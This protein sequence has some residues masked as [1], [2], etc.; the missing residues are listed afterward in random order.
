M[1]MRKHRVEQIAGGG[2]QGRRPSPIQPQLSMPAHA[3]RRN[4]RRRVRC[5]TC[6]RSVIAVVLLLPGLLL[7]T[8]FLLDLLFRTLVLL[9]LHRLLLRALPH[10]G[11]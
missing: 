11:A 9:L 1:E 4:Y 3:S 10:A 5:E 8:L 6:L 2:R 7:G